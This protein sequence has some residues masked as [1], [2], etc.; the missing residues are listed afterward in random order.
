MNK[1]VIQEKGQTYQALRRQL[2]ELLE[3]LQHPDCDVD[4]A[5]ELYEATLTVIGKLERH[6]ESAENRIRKVQARFGI[7]PGGL[8]AEED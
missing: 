6:L 4:E 7:Q 1:K 2:D 5:V 8:P 3:K